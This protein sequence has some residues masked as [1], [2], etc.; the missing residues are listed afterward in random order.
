MS[1]LRFHAKSPAVEVSESTGEME[2]EQ[3]YAFQQRANVMPDCLH[4]LRASVLA[5]ASRPVRPDGSA[6]RGSLRKDPKKK[7]SQTRQQ[8]PQGTYI[9]D[10]QKKCIRQ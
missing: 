2:G 9:G 3:G 8:A 1:C 5:R 6:G 7:N 4:H 10:P